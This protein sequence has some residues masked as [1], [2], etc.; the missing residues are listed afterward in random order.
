MALTPCGC[1]RERGCVGV[2]WWGRCAGWQAGMA[3]WTWGHCRAPALAAFG[4]SLR[5]CSPP[6]QRRAPG[7]RCMARR[8]RQPLRCR[9]VALAAIGPC[10]LGAAGA[11]RAEGEGRRALGAL[12]LPG[13]SAAAGIQ[14]LPA[15]CC[16]AGGHGKEGMVLPGHLRTPGTLQTPST[17]LP[18]LSL[19]GC[20]SPPALPAAAFAFGE[21]KSRLELSL[22]LHA[23]S[24]RAKCQIVSDTAQEG[25]MRSPGAPLA[26]VGTSRDA[27][28]RAGSRAPAFPRERRGGD[29]WLGGPAALPGWHNPSC[30]PRNFRPPVPMETR[31]FS[32]PQS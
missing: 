14:A 15:S 26:G 7:P 5:S 25:E 2:G 16:L 4:A 29:A 24:C 31:N 9:A 17:V 28:S 30:S 27:G 8:C 12:K 20:Q 10:V 1:G 3:A 19:P 23:P 11:G 13:I 32:S 6:G 22:H 21:E 18:V